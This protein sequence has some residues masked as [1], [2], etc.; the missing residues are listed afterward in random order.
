M[1]ELSMLA[2]LQT[3]QKKPW[4]WILTQALMETVTRIPLLMRRQA[5]LDELPRW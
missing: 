4:Q 3:D 5:M 2:P 1:L